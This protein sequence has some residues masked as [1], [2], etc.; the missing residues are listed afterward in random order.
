MT[1][2]E[3]A[4]LHSHL[5]AYVEKFTAER[6]GTSFVGDL[7]ECYQVS[8]GSDVA[9]MKLDDLFHL[10][11]KKVLRTPFYSLFKNLLRS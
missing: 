11:S 8:K 2:N 9:D 6:W 7:I 10:S 1:M 5:F 4:L 3:K